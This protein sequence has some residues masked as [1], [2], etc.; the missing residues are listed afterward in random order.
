M[1][2]LYLCYIYIGVVYLEPP[3]FVD[4]IFCA[5]Q[6]GGAQISE[7][8]FCVSSSHNFCQLR[9]AVAVHKYS[10][11]DQRNTL[12]ESEKYTSFQDFCQLGL[13]AAAVMPFSAI[14][15]L[16]FW[17]GGPGEPYIASRLR[18]VEICN[19]SIGARHLLRASVKFLR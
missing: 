5:H 19:I 9:L 4:S 3:S 17:V 16:I 7:T 2:Y 1:R 11:Q 15:G 13:V 6:P 8:C 18:F 10:L 14:T 12:C